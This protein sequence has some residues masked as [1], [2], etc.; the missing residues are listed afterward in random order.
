MITEMDANR[1]ATKSL[2]DP[3]I[4]RILSAALSAVDPYRAVKDHLPKITGNVYG[5]A[6]GKA[7][8]PMMSALAESIPLLDGKLELGQ[9]RLVYFVDF[10]GTRPRKRTV[11]VQIVGE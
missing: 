11:R 4:L 2:H 7:A 1:F 6:I 3:R 9:V 8:L 10:D 5:L